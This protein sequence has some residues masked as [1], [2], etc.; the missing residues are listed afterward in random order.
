MVMTNNSD[1][2]TNMTHTQRV[3]TFVGFNGYIIP[4]KVVGRRYWG[5][6][7]PANVDRRCRELKAKGLLKAETED[8]M[9]KWVPTKKFYKSIK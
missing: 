9:R 8:G 6:F 1:K 4:S 3:L 5:M 2:K 7:M